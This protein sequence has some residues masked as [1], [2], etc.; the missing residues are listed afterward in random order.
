MA[1]FYEFFENILGFFINQFSFIFQ[2]MYDAGGYSK[3]GLILIFIPLILL[4][5]FYFLWK[6]PYGRLWH[7]LVLISI[8]AIFA[9]GIT[10]GTTR[11][12]LVDYILSSDQDVANFAQN[13]VIKYSFLN[14]FLSLLVSFLWSLLLKQFSKIQMH[15]PF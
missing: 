13:L 10:Y 12:T 2:E 3:M 6:Y 1:A 11:L 5:I 4:L 8:A 14:G 7:W 9:A 15:L